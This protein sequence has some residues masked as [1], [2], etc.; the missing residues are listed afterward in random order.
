MYTRLHVKRVQKDQ[1]T[2]NATDT[3]KQQKEG[4][5]DGGIRIIKMEDREDGRRARS[6]DQ[7]A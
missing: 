4:N 6:E 3:R 1:P 7:Q 2:G 5:E